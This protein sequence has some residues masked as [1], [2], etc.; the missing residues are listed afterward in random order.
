MFFPTGGVGVPRLVIHQF[1]IYV[2]TAGNGFENP[3]LSDCQDYKQRNELA[4]AQFSCFEQNFVPNNTFSFKP[5][6][7]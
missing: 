7:W 6:S 3:C 2:L 1:G 4:K 5:W